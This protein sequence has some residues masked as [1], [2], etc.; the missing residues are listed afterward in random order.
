MKNNVNNLE[1]E[2]DCYI[3]TFIVP[4]LK[5]FYINKIFIY[6][7]PNINFTYPWLHTKIH[8]FDAY[9]VIWQTQSLMELS[10][11]W[12]S[13]T[14]QLLK[15]FPAF[16]GTRRSITAFTR[17]LHWF[18]TWVTSNQSFTFHSTSLRSILL[19]STHVRH[20]LPS[21]LLPSAFPPISYMHFSSPH[22]CYLSC[23]SIFLGLIIIITIEVEYNLWSSLLCSFLLHFSLDQI[24]SSTL[25]DTLSKVPP[26]MSDTK[27]H[28]HTD[29]QQNY[30]F[31]YSNFCF[32]TA[33]ARTKC[34]GRNGSKLY[35]SS[36]SS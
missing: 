14:V 11:S 17:A 13:A 6:I 15:K 19:L 10:P 27:F 22:S 23:H 36:I 28:T 7:I 24:I 26:L 3:D 12:G 31:L 2:N 4:W 30:K 35:Q 32:Y 1:L 9:S 29:S 16:Y 18:L 8:V 25:L 34:S 21:G 5:L 33:D 20:G